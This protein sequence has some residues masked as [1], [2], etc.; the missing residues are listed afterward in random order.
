MF[1]EPLISIT[2]PRLESAKNEASM[3]ITRKN[4]L[5]INRG[6][7]I[8]RIYNSYTLPI[9]AYEYDSPKVIYNDGVRESAKVQYKYSVSSG[10]E[11]VEYS[12]IIGLRLPNRG[13]ISYRI[14]KKLS[15]FSMIFD[16]GYYGAVLPEEIK[17]NAKREKMNFDSEIEQIKNALNDSVL[18]FNSILHNKIKDAIDEKINHFTDLAKSERGLD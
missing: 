8:L 4:Y 18:V 3:S 5:D 7:I 17:L 14:S 11:L 1:N 2:I 6:D 15:E 10:I 9:F 13:N 12:P 16:T